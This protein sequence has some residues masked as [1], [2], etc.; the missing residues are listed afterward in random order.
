MQIDSC[1]EEVVQLAKRKKP[2]NVVADIDGPCLLALTS[3][4]RSLIDLNLAISSSACSNP[5]TFV[6]NSKAESKAA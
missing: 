4:N 2:A 6:T 1:G 5:P 3:Y